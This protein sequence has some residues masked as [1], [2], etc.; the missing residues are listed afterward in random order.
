MDHF[1]YDDND[2]SN[3]SELREFFYADAMEKDIIAC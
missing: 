3:S 1:A 2:S